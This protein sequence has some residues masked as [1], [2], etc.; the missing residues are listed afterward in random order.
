MAIR[1]VLEGDRQ[2]KQKLEGFA[3][4]FP[5]EARR[6]TRVVANQKGDLAQARAPEKTGK[7]K[8]SKRI[9]VSIRRSASVTNISAT[10]KFGGPD[11]PYARIVHAT[12]PTKSKF[13]ESVMLE[14]VNTIGAD[15]AREI[16]LKKALK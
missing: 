4:E 6:G 7:L 16:D 3:R 9:A 12:H 8:A 11:V 2:M 13:L 5:L 1:M 10:V 15:L 14:S